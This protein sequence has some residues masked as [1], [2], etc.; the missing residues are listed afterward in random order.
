M[1]RDVIIHIRKTCLFLIASCLVSMA[2]A[3]DFTD[4]SMKV[5]GMKVTMNNGKL[6]VTISSDG[7]VSSY[8]FNQ[9][10]ELLASS[11]VYFD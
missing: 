11:G 1:K 8:K 9:S 6:L 4:V 7:R 2:F 3:T 5:D 10:K